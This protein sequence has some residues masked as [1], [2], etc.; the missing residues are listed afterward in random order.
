[1]HACFWN[2]LINYL[3][4]NWSDCKYSISQIYLTFE[5]RPVLKGFTQNLHWLTKGPLLL[6]I[7]TIT[8]LSSHEHLLGDVQVRYWCCGLKVLLVSNFSNQFDL[9]FLSFK[10][11]LINITQLSSKKIKPVWNFSNQNHNTDTWG[12]NIITSL[13]QTRDNYWR[14]GWKTCPWLVGGICLLYLA[15]MF[16]LHPFYNLPLAQTHTI[17]ILHL[18]SGSVEQHFPK[19]KLKRKIKA[20]NLKIS[21]RFHPG[22]SLTLWSP[23]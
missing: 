18:L 3:L 15:I 10:I 9:Y 5:A 8:N 20:I 2:S 6:N 12:R 13:N 1:M 23:R 19:S 11:M 16:I 22:S 4:A 21:I 7:P 14:K 17:F